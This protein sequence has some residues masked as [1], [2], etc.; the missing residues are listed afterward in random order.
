VRRLVVTLVLFLVLLAGVIMA[1]PKLIPMTNLQK[2][3][4]DKVHD[5]TGRDL[6]FSSAKLVF[7]PD[8][9][10]AL[11]DASLSNAPWGKEKHMLEVG[12][13]D[14]ALALAPL[15]SRHVE[16]KRLILKSPVV[17]LEKNADGHG[18]WELAAIKA[19][20]EGKP[21]PAAASSPAASGF[22]FKLGAIKVEDG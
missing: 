2:L 8:V 20:D 18:N 3:V 11:E 13:L 21:A 12:R 10:V 4:K 15:F 14:V 9:A 5:A 19:K 1:L 17:H 16:V 7:F 22:K 6:A